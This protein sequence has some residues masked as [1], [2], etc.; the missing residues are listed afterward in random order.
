MHAFGL[1]LDLNV[2]RNLYGTPGGMHPDIVAI[3]EKWGFE[4][5][6]RWDRPDPMHFELNSIVET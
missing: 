6:G 4:W 2:Q 1:A 3:F 5:G